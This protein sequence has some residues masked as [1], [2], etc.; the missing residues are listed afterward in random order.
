MRTNVWPRLTNSPTSTGV[1]TTRPET[2][3]ATSDDSSGLK[4]PV[5][6]IVTGSSVPDTRAVLT[7]TGAADAAGAGASA[8]PP[9]DAARVQVTAREI[10][11]LTLPELCNRG[12]QSRWRL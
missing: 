2:S 12:L 11:T 1:E 3:G 8:L 10:A 4:L 7:D 6:S 9:Q 5:A